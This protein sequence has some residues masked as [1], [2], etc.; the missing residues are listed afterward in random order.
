MSL[1]RKGRKASLLS[2]SCTYILRGST[3]LSG[4]GQLYLFEKVG[5]LV[6]F[7]F[8]LFLIL[9]YPQNMG[10]KA[11]CLSQPAVWPSPLRWRGATPQ[12]AKKYP[13]RSRGPVGTGEEDA[14]AKRRRAWPP[15]PWSVRALC[16]A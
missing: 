3:F 11:I 10:K 15:T 13:R 8:L 9:V 1:E 12:Q 6:L 16:R 14:M 4:G 7:Y 5:F 2:C